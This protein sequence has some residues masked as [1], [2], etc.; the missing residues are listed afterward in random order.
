MPTPQLQQATF[1]SGCFWC[2]EAIFKSLKGVRKVT[3]GYA[4]GHVAD[5][6]YEQVSSGRTGHAEVI[7]L[8]F[9][10]S[11]I[12]FEQLAEVFFLTHDPTQLN[13]QGNDRGEQYRSVI[14]THDEDQ[15]QTAEQIK[16]K[17]EAE[18]VFDGPIVTAIQPFD[19]F[20][21][22]ENYHQNYYANNPTQPYCQAIISPKVAKFREKFRSLL[23]A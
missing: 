19:G 3:S 8:E 2:S 22:A 15:R 7:Q 5:P 20:Y 10:P 11:V 16:A 14:L 17:L 4:G 9:D 1:G 6:T 13:R 18:N 21:P 12:R 23:S